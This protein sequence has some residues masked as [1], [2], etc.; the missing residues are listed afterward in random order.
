MELWPILASS[1]TTPC[2]VRACVLASKFW[3][4]SRVLAYTRSIRFAK[5]WNYGQFR[6]PQGPLLFGSRYKDTYIF[7]W[8]LM[9]LKISE[10]K[11]LFN[12]LFADFNWFSLV[13]LN[14]QLIFKLLLMIF[15]WFLLVLFD[16][17]WNSIDLSQVILL[18]S[19]FWGWCQITRWTTP[20]IF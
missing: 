5:V 13:L 7:L 16:F 18:H 19:T 20:W 2:W 6:P 15:D 4:W 9:V 11:L 1:G 10:K 3:F 17:E 12:H 14:L 8:I